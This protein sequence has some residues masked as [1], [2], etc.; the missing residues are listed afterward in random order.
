MFDRTSL[1]GVTYNHYLNPESN[2]DCI[3][4]YTAVIMRTILHCCVCAMCSA[5]TRNVFRS[6]LC[7]SLQVVQGVQGVQEVLWAVTLSHIMI[8][9]TEWSHL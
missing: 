7:H 8:K 6:H 1:I 2:Y 3:N 4:L 9:N 5:S